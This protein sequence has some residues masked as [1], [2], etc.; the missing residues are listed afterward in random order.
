MYS[1]TAQPA[2]MYI[3]RLTLLSSAVT[4]SEAVGEWWGQSLLYLFE[5]SAC[6]SVA[7]PIVAITA[8]IKHSIGLSSSLSKR[9]P[10]IVHVFRIGYLL[11]EAIALLLEVPQ[12]CVLVMPIAAYHLA[13]H[14]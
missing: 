8:A 13:L 5:R 3:A 1:S 12:Q 14:N 2:R 4:R 6:A 7:I 9:G 10:M 11:D